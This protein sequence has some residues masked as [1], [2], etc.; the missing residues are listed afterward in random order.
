VPLELAARSIGGLCS[1]VLRYGAG[2]SLED[3]IL[4]HALGR[5]PGEL[6]RDG[7]PAGVMMLPVP[8]EGRLQAV[9]GQDAARAVPGIQDLRI[10]VAPGTHVRPLPEG[11]R[12]L[13][14]LFATGDT[15]AD[16]EASL[17]RAAD[18][19]EVRIQ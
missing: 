19:L 6:R 14:F 11:D 9:D 7:D 18:A 12:Y 17:R 10:T 15:P 13:G 1:R 8:E 3:V 4:A 2:L 5:D 16:V